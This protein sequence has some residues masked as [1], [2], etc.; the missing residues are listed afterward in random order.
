MLCLRLDLDRNAYMNHNAD[1]DQNP[2]PN[3]GPQLNLYLNACMRESYKPHWNP[4]SVIVK[5][6]RISLKRS[7]DPVILAKDLAR[8]S[9]Y[10]HTGLLNSVMRRLLA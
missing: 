4:Y 3:Q 2:N 9:E 1:L 8:N 5:V 7:P 10:K 6:E